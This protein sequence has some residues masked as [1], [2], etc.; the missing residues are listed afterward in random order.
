MHRRWIRAALW[1]LFIF[2]VGCGE[3]SEER[4]PR[5]ENQL[6]ASCGDL[7]S[8]ASQALKP[9]GMLYEDSLGRDVLLRGVNTGGRSKFPP[10]FP[11]P[12]QESGYEGQEDAGSFDEEMALYVDKLEEWGHNVVRLVFS[13]EAVEPVR[14]E[15]DAV[16][17]ERLVRFAQHLSDRQIRVILDFHQDVYSRAFC[18]DGFPLWALSDPELEIP[19]IE[20][21]GNWFAAYLNKSGRVAEE[22]TRFWE[23]EDG[24]Q[25]A[26]LAM[27]R[28]V[29]E[30]TAHIDGVIGAEVM[31][32][33][34]EGSLETETWARDFMKP[35]V[36]DFYDV[37]QEVRPGLLVFFGSAGTDTLTGKTVVHLPE[38]ADLSFAPHFYDPTVYIFGTSR[39]RWNPPA[40][41]DNFWASGVD[42]QVPVLVGEMGCR[43]K[44]SLCD[45]YMHDVYATI[46]GY[47]MHA[48]AWEYSATKDDWNNEGFGLVDFGGVERDAAS[49]VVRVYPQAI[50]GQWESFGF[51]HTTKTAEWA[52][53]AK[54]GGWSELRV[55]SRLYPDGVHVQLEG[56][57]LC[58][59]FQSSS[60]VLYLRR[61]TAGSARV[62]VTP[63]NEAP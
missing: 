1:T 4:D 59:S 33:P 5:G 7:P 37:V 63:L 2:L 10:F 18:G 26:L 49:S 47:P 17:L 20:D 8:L 44:Q 22:F 11:F 19:P 32:E 56:E 40:V 43:T 45:A 35:L 6:T 54:A 38:R 57:G 25:D 15:Y 13:W 62:I 52:W 48:T 61:D 51:D 16:Y 42:W 36:E 34:W 30:E 21:C 12:F 53:E 29:L 28:K 50:D 55:P 58:A 46:D 14:G 27:W 3:S 24:L 41:L 60:D 31:N 9:R 39:G 23:N